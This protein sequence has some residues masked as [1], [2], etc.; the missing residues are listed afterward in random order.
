MKI[1]NVDINLYRQTY[2]HDSKEAFFNKEQTEK[3]Y[4]QSRLRK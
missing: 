3:I 4:D 2:N 1:K